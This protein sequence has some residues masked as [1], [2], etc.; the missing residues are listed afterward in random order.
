LI[1][2]RK[3]YLPLTGIQA[4]LENFPNYVA[5]APSMQY[6]TDNAGFSL[7]NIGSR[8][9]L[10]LT[11]YFSIGASFSRTQLK[12]VESVLDEDIISTY[13]YIGNI[14]YNTFKG[15][16]VIRLARDFT[17]G[18][19]MGR[20]SARGSLFRDEKDA[21]IRFERRDTISVSFNYQSSDASLI[22]YSPYL[23]DV[24]YYANLFRLEGYYKHRDG[25]KISG[26]FQYISVS[27]ANEGND[28]NLRLGKYFYKDLALGY[29]YYYTNYKYKSQYYY[30]PTNFESHSIWIDNEL[31]RKKDLRITLG[32]KLGIIPRNKILVLGAYLDLFYQTSRNLLLSARLAGQST[33]RDD[34]S[35]RS[36][37]AQFSAY[38]SI[39]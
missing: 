27:D 26:T 37:S 16:F 29:E 33:S 23:I 38:W 5:L 34:S 11:N 9:E 10:G 2:L 12:A 21:F 6:Y 28:F 30:S 35:Y 31:E 17:M 4:I 1:E 18:A 32:G 24:R 22:L 25:L 8:L 14:R 36:F 13:N 3:G 39:F 19:G 7:F 15:H 20:S